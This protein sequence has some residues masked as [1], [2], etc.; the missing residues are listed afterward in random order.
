MGSGF[1]NEMSSLLVDVCIFITSSGF[2]VTM[3]GNIRQ[4][5]TS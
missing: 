2:A 3:T 4:Q 5:A 1:V